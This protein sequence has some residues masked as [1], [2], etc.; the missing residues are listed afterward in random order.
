MLHV[1][2]TCCITE[3]MF[4]Q[5]PA[6]PT[7]ST[8]HGVPPSPDQP[9]MQLPIDTPQ[10]PTLQKPTLQNPTL[11]KPTPPQYTIP[12]RRSLDWRTA[13]DT[14]TLQGRRV[15][16]AEDNLI[17]QTVARKMLTSLGLACVVASNGAEAVA[18]VKRTMPG[19]STSV[20]AQGEGG[21]AKDPPYDCILM[22][23]MM[24]VMNG[25]EATVAL[26]ACGATLPIIAMTANASDADRDECWAAGMDGFLSK[27]VLKEQLAAAL[28]AALA[29]HRHFS[30]LTMPR[31]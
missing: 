12:P 9:C 22:D 16:L 26:R 18:A 11:Q 8:A 5:D 28:A 31:I 17:N 14:T 19:G 23:M 20:G 29:G 3:I 30:D 21:G 7:H 24:P 6:G 2:H 10:K 27:P 13:I 25:V 15:L 4:T 1:A